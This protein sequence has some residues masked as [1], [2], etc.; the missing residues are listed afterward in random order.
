[1]NIINEPGYIIAAVIVAFLFVLVGV[2]VYQNIGHRE[3][4]EALKRYTGKLTG[5]LHR[6]E[7]ERDGL[8]AQ[9][10]MLGENLK[11]FEEMKAQQDIIA[12][13]LRESCGKQIAMG[14]HNGRG[15]GEI[16]VGY[17]QGRMP[18]A[19]VLAM[20]PE[21]APVVVPEKLA[22]L[23]EV[24]DNEVGCEDDCPCTAH[25]CDCD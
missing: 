24:G 9:A 6:A 23:V 3:N 1:M 11:T 21:P 12:L 19:E 2:L 16:V 7:G 4:V 25:E 17:L 15:I 18:S 10:L 20:M 14:L 13:Y 22:H 8:R 5:E